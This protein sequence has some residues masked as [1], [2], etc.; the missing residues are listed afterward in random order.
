MTI[1]ELKETCGHKG[2]TLLPERS[3]FGFSAD[4]L[5]SAGIDPET[6]VEQETRLQKER[7]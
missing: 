1:A 2:A 3:D 6:S 5:G 7:Q 4:T